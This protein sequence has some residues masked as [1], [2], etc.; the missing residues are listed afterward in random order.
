MENKK[1]F[2]E[3]LEKLNIKTQI[4]DNTIKNYL[5]I[6]TKIDGKRIYHK[7]R[8]NENNKQ[9]AFEKLS[10]IQQKLIKEFTVD[11]E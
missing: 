9:E 4:K 3:R 10:E 8:Y 11:W 2:D 6:D 5:V 7:C 1:Q